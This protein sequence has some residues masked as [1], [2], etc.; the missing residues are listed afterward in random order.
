MYVNNIYMLLWLYS[1]SCRKKIGSF[2]FLTVSCE[3]WHRKNGITVM[4]FSVIFF[5]HHTFYEFD[6]LS[7][8]R[9]HIFHSMQFLFCYSFI[10]TLI[11]FFDDIKCSSVGKLSKLNE[12]RDKKK[13]KAD[14]RW[15]LM[16]V[17]NPNR[18]QT[19]I[20]LHNKK[21]LKSLW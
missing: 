15:L 4:T 21:K 7:R 8:L 10:R 5:F 19:L 9:H 3:N 1:K 14:V 13:Q 17:N 16:R 20:N 2:H 18:K 6:V 12:L 11:I